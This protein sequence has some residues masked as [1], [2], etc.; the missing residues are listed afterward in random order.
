MTILPGA[1]H[2]EYYR[3][4]EIVDAKIFPAKKIVFEYRDNSIFINGKAIQGLKIMDSNA[5]IKGIHYTFWENATQIRSARR[6]EASIDDPFVY[7]APKSAMQGWSEDEICRELGTTSAETEVIVEFVVPVE[8]VWLKASR[9]VV[10]F[11]VEGM[12]TEDEIAELT[13]QRR[14]QS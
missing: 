5:F 2:G 4:K 7:F 11:A 6:L 3:L 8:R 14:K 13:I 1:S 9:A 10:H 12:I